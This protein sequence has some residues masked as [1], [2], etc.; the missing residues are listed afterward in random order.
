MT[1]VQ[2]AEI[3]EDRVTKWAKRLIEMHS[4][5]F[6]L[7]GFGHDH[8]QGMAVTCLEEGVTVAQTIA[9]LEKTIQLLK[10]KV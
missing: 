6:I 5:P 1:Q 7:I 3:V 8:R 2:V 10:E 4:T 9:Y